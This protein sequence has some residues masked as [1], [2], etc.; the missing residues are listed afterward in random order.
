MIK[1]PGAEL[2]LQ[3]K[4][5]KEYTVIVLASTLY[6]FSTHFFIFPFGIFL[7]DNTA[8]AANIGILAHT[9]RCTH[10]IGIAIIGTEFTH[11]FQ[12][13]LLIASLVGAAY[14]NIGLLTGKCGKC[15]IKI[16]IV[17]GKKTIS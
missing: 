7:G 8:A 11:S 9:D 5:L 2:I 4:T 12:C 14:D 6:A 16:K 3:R 13:A 10:N 17:T 15:F 1:M